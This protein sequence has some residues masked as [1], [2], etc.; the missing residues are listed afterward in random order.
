MRRK[1]YND[2]QSNS[3]GRN[4][5]ALRRLRTDEIEMQCIV[6]E[7]N[8]SIGF[9]PIIWLAEMFVRTCIIITVIATRSTSTEDF[10]FQSIDIYIIYSL[11]VTTIIIVGRFDAEYDIN[12]I[13]QIVNKCF[14]TT[15]SIDQNL[16]AEMIR[17]LQEASNRW[18]NR[19]KACGL[20]QINSNLVLAFINSVITFSVMFVQLK[21]V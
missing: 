20:F 19:P 5:E 7:V 6:E 18:S 16:N 12:R 11:L 2:L 21:A 1:H 14:A 10:A 17:Y 3:F 8:N 9:I 13:T 15:K 4:L